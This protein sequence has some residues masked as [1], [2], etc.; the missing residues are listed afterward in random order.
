M[1][2]EIFYTE[3]NKPLTK[4]LILLLG[5]DGVLILLSVIRLVLRRFFDSYQG[6]LLSDMFS[7]IYDRGLGEYFQYF[8]E[9]WIVVVFIIIFRDTRLKIYVGWSVLFFYVFLDDFFQIHEKGGEIFAQRFEG[10]SFGPFRAQDVGELLVLSVIGL[11]L[12]LILFVGFRSVS[13]IHRSRNMIL[14]VLLVVLV[15]FGV[16]LDV[17]SSVFNW[18][19]LKMVLHLVEDGG[20]MIVIS[21]ILWAVLIFSKDWDITGVSQITE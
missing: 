13:N 15:G 4:V 19:E 16:I 2:K 5:I 11:L 21:I 8:K 17:V 12:L 6:I 14:G 10:I 1:L 7:I 20:E 18:Y 9:I 3:R